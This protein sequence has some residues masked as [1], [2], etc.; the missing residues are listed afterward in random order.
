VYRANLAYKAVRLEK[1]S[2]TVHFYFSS[3]LV[4][5]FY[6]ITGLNALVWLLI[7]VT[8]AGKMV[9]PLTGVIFPPGQKEN[10]RGTV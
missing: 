9:W 10:G 1:G 2:N 6:K 7:I 8:T 4:S 3:N 5:W